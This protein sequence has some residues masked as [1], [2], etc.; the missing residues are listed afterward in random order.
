M[1]FVAKTCVNANSLVITIPY[2][3]VKVM[4]LKKDDYLDVEITLLK[5]MFE[6]ADKVYK[7]ECENTQEIKEEKETKNG[8]KFKVL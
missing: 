3:L 7:R 1:K 5:D 6:T 2:N 8:K 4:K